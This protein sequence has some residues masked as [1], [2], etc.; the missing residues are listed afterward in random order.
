MKAVI[1]SGGRA[2]SLSLLKLE[3]EDADLLI[4]VDSGGNY[5]RDNDIIP[6]YLVGDF[7]SINPVTLEYFKNSSCTVHEYP[8]DK[9]FT[10]TELALELAVKLNSD[11]IAF[12]GCTG[13]RL[14]HVI[15]NLG[16]LRTC[17]EKDVNGY[18]KDD[19]NSIM[20]SKTP[21]KISGKKGSTFSVQAFCDTVNNLS[22]K[23]AKYPLYDHK[24]RIGDP[25]TISNEFLDE[26]VEIYFSD[27]LLMILYTKD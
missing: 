7:D 18:I 27:G 1:F 17:L 14:D 3:L 9:D 5:L 13:T 21:L 23:G 24:L 15:G 6:D 16:L 4:G 26:D 22:I 2:P 10:D 20:L 25:L 8:R 19:H 12:L 11:T